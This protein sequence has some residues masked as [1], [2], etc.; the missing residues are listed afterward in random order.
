MVKEFDKDG[1]LIYDGEYLNGQRS[2]KGKEYTMFFNHK[3]RWYSFNDY[4][5]TVKNNDK[6]DEVKLL[7]EGEYLN[8]KRHGKGKEYDEFDGLLVFEGEY[9]NGKKWNGKANEIIRYYNY[10]YYRNHSIM[11]KL[12]FKGEYLNGKRNGKLTEFFIN[13]N[14]KFVGE[15]LNGLKWNGIGYDINNNVIYQIKDGNGLVKEYDD[16]E[17]SL[18]YFDEYLNGKRKYKKNKKN[19]LIIIY[20]NNFV[21]Y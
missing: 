15:Y 13:G 20:N 11:N 7:Y 16:N 14:K 12:I 10:E 9:L 8:G 3:F 2:G 17:N 19:K 21:Y 5:G 4:I 6:R 1:N 18:T